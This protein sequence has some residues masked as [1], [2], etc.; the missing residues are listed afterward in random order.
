MSKFLG[1]V[2]K[3]RKDK[4]D[5]CHNRIK[6]MLYGSMKTAFKYITTLNHEDK[7][8]YGLV[9]ILLAFS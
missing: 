1:K 4:K 6:N 3:Y 9:K 8:D 7:P 5:E 2:L